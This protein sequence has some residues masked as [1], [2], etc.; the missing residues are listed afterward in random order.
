MLRASVRVMSVSRGFRSARAGAFPGLSG[1]GQPLAGG[2]V[3]Q[4]GPGPLAG[5]E[6]EGGKALMDQH[7]QAA[8]RRQSARLR[9][10]DKARALRSINDVVHD[11][12]RLEILGPQGTGL[13]I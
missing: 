11:L 13:G 12:A 10:E 4:I 3:E 9:I 2:A 7:A 6:R 8:D 1:S 5:P